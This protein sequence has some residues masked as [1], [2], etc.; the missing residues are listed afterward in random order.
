MRPLPRQVGEAAQLRRGETTR[1]ADAATEG[2]A[3]RQLGFQGK[4]RCD[5]RF[6]RLVRRDV[7]NGD[8]RIDAL[9]HSWQPRVREERSLHFAKN[10]VTAKRSS[11]VNHG[12]DCKFTIG[13]RPFILVR[14]Q[15]VAAKIGAKIHGG[16]A[17]WNSQRVMR[18]P[19]R[20]VEGRISHQA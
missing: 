4:G 11:S 8:I 15:F 10:T 20:R 14:R 7:A 6:L 17:G 9:D 13:E 16:S 18:E 2:K 1:R 19:Q 5:V 3:A 12:V